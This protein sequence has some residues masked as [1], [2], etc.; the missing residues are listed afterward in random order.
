MQMDLVFVLL[1]RWQA[2]RFEWGRCDCVLAV[3][4]YVA[5]VTGRDPA[6][7]LRLTY[8][9]AGE[10]Q[11]MTR[12]FT[13]PM[14]VVAPRMDAIG[15]PRTQAPRRGDVGLILAPHG[16][17]VQPYGAICV[18]PD[19]WGVKVEDGA[20]VLRPVKVLAAWR[21]ECVE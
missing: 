10:C 11:R 6:E 9:S 20:E 17:H 16:A 14:G 4:D 19:Q 13:D 5:A 3:A 7:D 21:V 1:N 8:G 2:A 18:G 15:L 12:F